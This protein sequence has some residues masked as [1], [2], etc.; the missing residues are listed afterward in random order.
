MLRTTHNVNISPS[1]YPIHPFTPTNTPFSGINVKVSGSGTTD[2]CASGADCAIGTALYKKDDAGI[3][4]N[5][6]QTLSSYD[7]PG[8]KLYGSGGAAA[9]ANKTVKR[10]AT[11]FRA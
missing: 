7:I 1:P 10:V 8:P 5:I 9:A 3:L 6:Y 2:P 11:A 4:I